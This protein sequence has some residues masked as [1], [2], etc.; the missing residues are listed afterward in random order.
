MEQQNKWRKAKLDSQTPCIGIASDASINNIYVAYGKTIPLVILDTVDYP[1]ID[2]MIQ[3]HVGIENGHLNTTWVTTTDDKYLLLLIE[4]ISPIEIKFLIKFDTEKHAGL[5][6][7][8]VNSQLLYIQAGKQGE[9]LKQDL[10]RPKVLMEVPC[11]E[12]SDEWYRIYLR[13]YTK[14]F[15]KLGYSK[16]DAVKLSLKMREEWGKIRDLQLRH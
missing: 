8:I 7:I 5:I 15:R 1:E 14:H 2:R 11:I 16:K 10:D 9:R 3:S 4:V 13:V 6:D 12:F